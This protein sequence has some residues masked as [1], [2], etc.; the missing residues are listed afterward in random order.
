MTEL[1]S[2]GVASKEHGENF[3]LQSTL[4]KLIFVRVVRVAH[5]G[6]CFGVRDAIALA[7]E[8]AAGGPLTILGDLFHN[9]TVLSALHAKGIAVAQDVRRDDLGARA[10]STGRPG[11]APIA[12]S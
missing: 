7:L 10:L 5:L 9:P 2:I 1:D 4:C 11:Q 8:H 6:M 12:A 3:T